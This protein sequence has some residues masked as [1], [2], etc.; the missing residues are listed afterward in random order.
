MPPG[1]H[2]R[3]R[4][5]YGGVSGNP[6]NST[7][8]AGELPGVLAEIAAVAGREA[9]LR[10]ALEMGGETLYVPKPDR[11]THGHRLVTAVGSACARRIAQR[12]AGESIDVPLARRALAVWLAGRDMSAAQ[13]GRALSI[14]VQTAR[15]YTRQFRGAMTP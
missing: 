7:P 6:E 14:R 8:A 1:R 15:K 13:I 2:G 11:L 5:G 4:P 9:A 3:T 12:F 10:L